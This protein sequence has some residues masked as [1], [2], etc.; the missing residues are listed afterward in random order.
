MPHLCHSIC[1]HAAVPCMPCATSAFL[2]KHLFVIYI[3]Y[4]THRCPVSSVFLVLQVNVWDMFWDSC[5][6]HMVSSHSD[7]AAVHHPTG[8]TDSNETQTAAVSQP[9]AMT[10]ATTAPQLDVS[11]CSSVK[12]PQQAPISHA[13]TAVDLTNAAADAGSACSHDSSCKLE[14]VVQ[15]LL[16]LPAASQPTQAAFTRQAELIADHVHTYTSQLE[17]KPDQDMA[18]KR[19]QGTDTGPA[20]V[21]LPSNSQQAMTA[22]GVTDQDATLNQPI[23]EPI[24]AASEL[25]LAATD[26]QRTASGDSGDSSTGDSSHSYLADVDLA[27]QCVD[28]SLLLSNHRAEG[29]DER[30]SHADALPK[31]QAG[32]FWPAVELIAITVTW[33]AVM[34][35]CNPTPVQ[36]YASNRPHLPDPEPVQMDR[37]DSSDLD[38]PEAAGHANTVPEVTLGKTADPNLEFP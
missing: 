9:A 4:T 14:A 10:I 6:A 19:G 2:C 21:P 28:T 5:H 27:M 22:G 30:G 1:Q 36:C 12:T 17:Q 37:A 15:T 33:F 23:A 35:C 3:T 25:P 32:Y 18:V 24:A 29:Y 34:E 26:E 8:Y 11:S 31:P 13:E 20:G 38:E 16:P 7:S